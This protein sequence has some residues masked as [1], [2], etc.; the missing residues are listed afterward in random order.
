MVEDID[1]AG[2]ARAMEVVGTDWANHILPSG[3]SFNEI[4][5]HTISWLKNHGYIIAGG[6]CPWSRVALTE[7]GLSAMNAV[8]SQLKESVGAELK[9]AVDKGSTIDLSAIGDLIGGMF[10]GF[11]KSLG[12][13]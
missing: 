8:P 6:G 1:Q 12:S 10:G 3:R 5:V 9:K 4:L 11:T 7:K 2:I 13:G